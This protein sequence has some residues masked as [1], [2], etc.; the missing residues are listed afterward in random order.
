MKSKSILSSI[1]ILAALTF[2]SFALASES[3][4]EIDTYDN[5]TCN[6][7]LVGG[8]IGPTPQEFFLDGGIQAQVFFEGPGE[9]DANDD[10]GNNRDDVQQ[11]L[12]AM[13]LAGGGLTLRLNPARQTL[14]QIEELVNNNLGRLDVDPF[15]PGDAESFFDIFLKIDVGGGFLLNNIQAIRMEAV[16][17][18]KP[19]AARY[20]YVLPSG[21]IE[22][23]D[24]AGSPT[25]I[26]LV[27]GW[28]NTEAVEID[29]CNNAFA[30]EVGQS[31][32]GSTVGA[33]G[34]VNISGC[35]DDDIYDVWYSFTPTVT[36]D[37]SISLCGS[38]FDTTLSVF[39]NCTPKSYLAC[40]DN[41]DDCS[42]DSRQSQLNI[43][44]TAD[45]TYL[46][47]IA[48]Q[49]RQRGSYILNI[50]GCSGP[51]VG[52]LNNDCKVNFTDIALIAENWLECNLKPEDLCLP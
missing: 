51:L 21:P 30:V 38:E 20:L 43:N 50:N 26:F 18:E 28:H 47:R 36:G 37:Y 42:R 12:V 35:T 29:N 19:G 3:A 14:G 13:N 46:I 2:T 25:G 16:I 49:N 32:Y 31:Y 6:L 8:P 48:G 7:A 39:D 9:G 1:A 27:D 34:N 45:N 4:V 52:D 17:N 22:L 41:S 10:D 40:N 33:S 5:T 15:H 44:L 23:H 24:A 11:E